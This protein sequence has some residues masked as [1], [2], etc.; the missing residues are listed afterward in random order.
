VRRREFLATLGGAVASPFAVRAEQKSSMRRIG[1]LI[2]N[3]ANDAE[4]ENRTKMFEQRLAELGWVRNHNLIIDYRW[5]AENMAQAQQLADELIALGPDVLV[6]NGLPP[7]RA[8]AQSTAAIPIVFAQIADPVV[9]GFVA[10]L[11][12]PGGNVTGFANFEF[13]IGGKWLEIMKEAAPAVTRVLAIMDR[14]MITNTAML[15]AMI[16]TAPSLGIHVTD[17]SGYESGDLGRRSTLLRAS[18][19]EV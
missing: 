19:T 6:G 12:R 3:P 9:T 2:N 17:W 5:G 10:T 11:A 13:S 1:V 14:A 16:A 7:L 4:W 15:S 8:L 18:R